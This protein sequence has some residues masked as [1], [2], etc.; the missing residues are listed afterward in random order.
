MYKHVIRPP[1]DG[2]RIAG[3]KH[4]THDGSQGLRPLFHGAER[5]SRPVE[6]AHTR[7]HLAVSGKHGLDQLPL[8]R[9]HF[10]ILRLGGN[11][12]KVAVTKRFGN[13][14]RRVQL[15]RAGLDARPMV[16]CGETLFNAVFRTTQVIGVNSLDRTDPLEQFLPRFLDIELFHESNV[17]AVLK[18]GD[19]S[20]PRR[21]TS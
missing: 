5:R 15:K 11:A 9:L 12:E 13:A 18:H 20:W 14:I 3:V 6:R 19:E 1:A 7:G 10:Q 8:A 4:D 17:P 16:F 21:S 2:H